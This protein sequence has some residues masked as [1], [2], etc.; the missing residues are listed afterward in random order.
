MKTVS[1]K[2]LAHQECDLLLPDPKRKCLMAVEDACTFA[3]VLTLVQPLLYWEDIC[4]LQ[5]ALPE[6]QNLI[7]ST[8][9]KT[10]T[11]LYLRAC[12]DIDDEP[13]LNH[14]KHICRCRHPRNKLLNPAQYPHVQ[15]LVVARGY[16]HPALSGSASELS[17][18]CNLTRL[19]ICPPQ[20]SVVQKWWLALPQTLV[21]LCLFFQDHMPFNARL[22]HL[23][24][25]TNLNLGCAIGNATSKKITDRQN[26]PLRFLPPNLTALKICHRGRGEMTGDILCHFPK[27]ITWLKVVS[28]NDCSIL[29]LPD[30]LV[31]LDA[32]CD[33]SIQL[34]TTDFDDEGLSAKELVARYAP[35]NWTSL[36]A[37][38]NFIVSVTTDGEWI[39]S[40]MPPTITDL[41][42]K[43]PDALSHPAL[44]ES[45][46]KIRYFRRLMLYWDVWNTNFLGNFHDAQFLGVSVHHGDTFEF[47]KTTMAQS[48]HVHYSDLDLRYKPPCV[49]SFPDSITRL[50]VTRA[51][52]L[53]DSSITFLLPPR[54][55]SLHILGPRQFI[56]NID[57]RIDTV[58]LSM[59]SIH[60][61][62]V[63]APDSCTP[64]VQ[65]LGKIQSRFAAVLR[66][67][68][69]SD[70]V[71][72]VGCVAED[73]TS[74]YYTKKARQ[75]CQLQDYSM[76]GWKMKLS[77]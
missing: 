32:C 33:S 23:L 67:C 43:H 7:T 69:R 64:D 47:C 62:L 9:A 50:V 26:S 22:N 36:A 75:I 18:F 52:N 51:D 1:K 15:D 41:E 48:F 68:K 25:V 54:I 40:V 53:V 31:H 6:M 73:Y 55:K 71:L 10:T 19:Y 42:L 45:L 4:N 35:P 12:S 77:V 44:F 59:E 30:A 63:Y 56:D 11:S 72:S 76:W 46:S 3:S 66:A 70:I 37:P 20:S 34:E 16:A 74:Q 38:T 24:N 57:I 65:G 5:N 49:C 60:I 14:V 61:T 2:R 8:L 39:E 21:D 13:R 17:K 29:D 58:P 28:I 27:S